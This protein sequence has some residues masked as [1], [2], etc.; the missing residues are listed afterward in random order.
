M[1]CSCH[2]CLLDPLHRAAETQCLHTPL[3]SLHAGRQPGRVASCSLLS[4]VCWCL[5]LG[6]LPRAV[7]AGTQVAAQADPREIQLQL[8]MHQ[9]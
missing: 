9:W 4:I 5:Q 1:M 6:C 7:L 8:M 3:A 2:V